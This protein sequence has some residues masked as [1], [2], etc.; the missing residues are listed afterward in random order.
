M[1]VMWSGEPSEYQDDQLDRV[2][3]YDPE[4]DL[5]LDDLYDRDED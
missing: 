5:L 2:D 4:L 3:D 1:T